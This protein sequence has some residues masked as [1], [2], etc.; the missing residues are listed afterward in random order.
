MSKV[1][2]IYLIRDH[3]TK[4]VVLVRAPNPS[5]ALNYYTRDRFEIE[6]ASVEQALGFKPEDVI[7]ASDTKVHPDQKPLELPE[8]KQEDVV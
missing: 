5:Q 7:D 2:R 3:E 1:T 6:V 8:G 4:K